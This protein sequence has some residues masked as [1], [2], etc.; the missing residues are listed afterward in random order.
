MN[1]KHIGSDFDD[2]LAEEGIK[3]EVEAAARARVAAMQQP[4]TDDELQRIR[5][6]LARH[7]HDAPWSGWMRHMF[8]L[9]TLE[10]TLNG[11]TVTAIPVNKVERWTRQMNTP[12]DELPESE[13]KSDYVEADAVL[14]LPEIKALLAEVERLRQLEAQ[15]G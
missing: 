6:A 15:Y 5:T 7:M 1:P 13:R 12:F 2:F 11:A 9:C 8:G 14:A 10:T 4:M 3:D